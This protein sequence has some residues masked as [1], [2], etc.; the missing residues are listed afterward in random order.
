[1]EEIENTV[2][3]IV[4]YLDEK[5]N[6]CILTVEDAITFTDKILKYV[7]KDLLLEKKFN[8]QEKELLDKL[9]LVSKQ[10]F[11]KTKFSKRW[12]VKEYY[13]TLQEK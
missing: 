13:Y 5:V 10:K 1:M 12:Y 7:K 4:N 6:V 8:R 9:L 3:S 2:K 11:L